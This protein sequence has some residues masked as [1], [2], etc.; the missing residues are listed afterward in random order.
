MAGRRGDSLR[1]R[2]ER[3]DGRQTDDDHERQYHGVF[4]CGRS[5]LAL[6]EP[7]NMVQKLGHDEFSML[8]GTRVPWKSGN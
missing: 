6:Y 7:A 5:I 8:Q 2:L 1:P 4:D 3:R